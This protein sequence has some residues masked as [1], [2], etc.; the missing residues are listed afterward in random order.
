[1][2][3]FELNRYKRHILLKEIGGSGQNILKNSCITMIGAGGLLSL[4]EN[5]KSIP[6]EIGLAGFNGVELLDGLP[7]K[8]ATMDACRYQIGKIAAE[9]VSNRVNGHK[10]DH[11]RITSLKPKL[12]LGDTLR[13]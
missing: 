1:M 8:L 9:I 7:M 11:E 13:P 12:D 3:K 6:K 5:Q 4:L 10:K 2:D